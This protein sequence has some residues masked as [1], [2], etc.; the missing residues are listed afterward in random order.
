[1]LT[2]FCASTISL[3]YLQKLPVSLLKILNTSANLKAR[4]TY[5]LFCSFT[6]C[7]RWNRKNSLLCVGP[8]ASVHV[9]LCCVNSQI[10]CVTY[11]HHHFEGTGEARCS[12]TT[13]VLQWCS[14]W[15]TCGFQQMELQ[16]CRLDWQTV[17]REGIHKEVLWFQNLKHCGNSWHF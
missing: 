11:T 15:T 12:E 5:F 3:I 13:G 6:D 7:N 4:K 16:M 8:W 17:Y 1:M 9:C 10:T 2:L 14:T